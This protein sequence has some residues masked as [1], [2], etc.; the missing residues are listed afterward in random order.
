MS[1]IEWALGALCV[2]LFCNFNMNVAMCTDCSGPH[3]AE[4]NTKV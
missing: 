3:S 1:F 4:K 2:H